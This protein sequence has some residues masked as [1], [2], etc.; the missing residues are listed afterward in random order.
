MIKALT[1]TVL[2]L[3]LTLPTLCAQP[4]PLAEQDLNAPFG[5]ATIGSI[6]G[7]TYSVTGGNAQAQ[8]ST[9]TL[10]ASRG[11]MQPLLTQALRTYDIVILDGSHGDFAVSTN[12]EMDHLHDK[13]LVGVN[14]AC[15]RTLFEVNEELRAMLDSAGVMAASTAGGTGGE[16]SNGTKVGEA[17][18]RLTRQAIINYTDD[19]TESYRHAGVLSIRRCENIIV[20]NLT[21]QGP[22]SVDVGG[23]DVISC[24]G[25]RHVWIDHCSLID[26]MDGNLDIT[27]GSDCVTCSWCTFSYTDRS[28]DHSNSNL[29]GSGD[30]WTSDEDLLNITYACCMWGHAV[31]ARMPMARYGTLHMLNNYYNCA[32]NGSPCIN[33]RRHS[34]FL[35]EGNS[36]AK[37]VKHVFN[38][39]EA[40]RWTWRED[41]LITEP[42]IKIASCGEPVVM[43][44]DYLVIPAAEVS[45]LIPRHAGPTLSDPLKIGK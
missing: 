38:Q 19:E 15:I 39:S 25:S 45:T 18:E 17:R 6:E 22:G 21:L 32:G 41:N 34:E 2:T 33:P 5:W 44:Y 23:N 12:I 16:L 27:A 37:G 28:Y 20:R 10:T 30:K 36:F 11:D 13:T 14:G 35:I 4:L 8:P 24:N 40:K 9:I 29:V 7:G 3:L 26:G 42:G 31:N 43:P 1:T